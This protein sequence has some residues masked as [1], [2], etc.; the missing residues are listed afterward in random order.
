MFSS[1]ATLLVVSLSALY[2]SAAITILAP[3]SEFWWVADSTNLYSWTCG[4]QYNGGYTNFTVLI[5]NQN[6]A[7]FNGPQALV[8]IQWDYDCSVDL[9]ASSTAQIPV[10]TGY[11]LSF[12]DVY[13]QT[14]VIAKSSLFEVKASGSVYPTQPSGVSSATVTANATGTGV[15]STSTSTPKNTKK[16][17]ATS[18]H[19]VTVGLFST[20]MALVGVSLMM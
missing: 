14:N 18:S 1:L 20:V 4:A 7:L 6:Q 5:Q 3:S 8:A 19:T 16:S 9:P 11:T 17:A 2:V 15:A 10:G 13:N 12:S